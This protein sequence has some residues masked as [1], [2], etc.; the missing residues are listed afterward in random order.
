MHL[1]S[2]VFRVGLFLSYFHAASFLFF[3]C[4]CFLFSFFFFSSGYQRNTGNATYTEGS[5]LTKE[6]KLKLLTL[7]TLCLE[8]WCVRESQE[9]LKDNSQQYWGGN[10]CSQSWAWQKQLS[11]PA[12]SSTATV[13]TDMFPFVQISV[14][15]CEWW[16]SCL[17]T[18][19]KESSSEQLPSKDKMQDLNT[20]SL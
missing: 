8:K 15:F 17:L 11:S 19:L 13:W 12:F 18:Y 10:L 4:S 2:Y 14:F 7:L 3:L 1:L 5:G 20:R 6:K 16:T 9:L